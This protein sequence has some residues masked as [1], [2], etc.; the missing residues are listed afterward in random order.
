MESIVMI[1]H[2][3]FSNDIGFTHCGPVTPCGDIDLGQ[4]RLSQR[5]DK[6]RTLLRPSSAEKELTILY[7]IMLSSNEYL[8]DDIKIVQ[9]I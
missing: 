5:L 7:N 9:I 3:W 6:T 1:R 8:T 2:N 4:Y